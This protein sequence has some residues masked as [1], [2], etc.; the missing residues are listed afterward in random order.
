MRT[1]KQTKCLLHHQKLPLNHLRPILHVADL[2]QGVARRV[3]RLSELGVLLGQRGRRP[4][5]R[6]LLALEG[7]GV[8]VQDPGALAEVRFV[9]LGRAA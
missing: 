9:R 4:R 5:Q 1:L 6:V 7:G 8:V 2:L 3:R